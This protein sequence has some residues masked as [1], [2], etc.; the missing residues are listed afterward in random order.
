MI[1]AAI[2]GERPMTEM[3]EA[4]TQRAPSIAGN[5]AVP[6]ANEFRSS[7]SVARRSNSVPPELFMRVTFPTRAGLDR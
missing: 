3:R 7:R 2:I 1:A 5:S 4:F 6:P